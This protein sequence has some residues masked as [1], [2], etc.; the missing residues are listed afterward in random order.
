M[1][2]RKQDQTKAPE[3]LP[4]ARGSGRLQANPSECPH[5]GRIVEVELNYTSDGEATWV[6]LVRLSVPRS[7]EPARSGS[8]KEEVDGW[9]AKCWRCTWRCRMIT[10]QEAS[11]QLTA[12]LNAEHKGWELKAPN[13]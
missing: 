9:E 7:Y 6:N 10:Y 2:R 5:C 4:A 8:I 11:I 13:D 3:P 12:H 1:K